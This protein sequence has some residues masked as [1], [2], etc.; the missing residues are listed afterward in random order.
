MNQRGSDRRTRLRSVI[1]SKEGLRRL[2]WIGGTVAVIVMAVLIGF[3]VT[4]PPPA[5]LAAVETFPDLGTEHIPAGVSAPEY[6]SDPPTSGPHVDTPAPCGIYRQAVP[7]VSVLH[8]M[9]HG[10]VV[11]HYD[12]SIEPA[13]QA[14][15][16]DIARSVGGELIVTPRPDMGDGI[17]LTAWTKRLSV[18][19][20]E[21]NVIR[22]FVTEFANRSP[23]GAA[24]CPFQI[25][26]G[27]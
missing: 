10:A 6:N 20:I 12:P 2:G 3:N 16:E 5:E 8:S 7:D 21:E 26:Q 9:E 22:A 27:A 1:A 23:E 15:L 17:V 24:A 18:D 11:I 25:D 14:Q 13:L 4:A 19:G